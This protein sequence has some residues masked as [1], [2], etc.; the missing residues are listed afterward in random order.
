[1]AQRSRVLCKYFM[2]GA[3]YKGDSC[4]FSHSWEDPASNVCVYYQR[5]Y[6][7]YG[8]KCR[9]EHVKVPNPKLASAMARVLKA[10]TSASSSSAGNATAP[11]NGSSSGKKSAVI[12]ISPPV[13]KA[14]PS[15][16]T[17]PQAK[18]PGSSM[19]IASALTSSGQGEGSGEFSSTS[20]SPSSRWQQFSESAEDELY[21][22]EQEM[23]VARLLEEDDPADEPICT[24]GINGQCT[25][26]A[27]CT[28]LH[29]DLCP[30]CGK[31]C[32]HPLRAEEREE[33]LRVCAQ[34]RKRLEAM[35]ISQDIECV[36]CLERVLSK[37]NLAERKFGI[38]SGCDH[39]FCIS[40][41]RSWRNGSHP[42]G[43]DL[44]T[45]IRGCPVCRVVSHYVIPSL[46]WFSSPEEKA[47]IVNG[48]KKKL[49]SLD[50]RYFD[51]GNGTCPF[52]TSCFYKHAY[53]DGRL[54]EIKLRHLGAADG[55][56]VIAK[57]IR[58]SDFIGKLDLGR[59][60]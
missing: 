38:L 32:L 58:L 40:C 11:A 45:I 30:T 21:S 53:K 37:P 28:H 7:A 20:S 54:E 59:S 10:S 2:H 1:M 56:A 19:I 50:C 12:G 6:C 4:E 35:L 44:K 14:S 5:G 34:N 24:L 42:P 51:Q 33:H 17:P 55:S 15:V 9:Y 43:M 31:N 36:V 29:G 3:C 60:G 22:I 48:Y 26:G 18:S 52:G 23:E 46:T 25:R 13:S 57:N 41:V 39:P 8:A 16:S 47:E 27:A 49:S